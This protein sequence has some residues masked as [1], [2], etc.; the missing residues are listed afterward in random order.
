MRFAVFKKYFTIFIL[1]LYLVF[2][3]ADRT[4]PQ[5]EL[6]FGPFEA[7]VASFSDISL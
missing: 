3:K 5:A 1:S 2:V 6:V 4:L 7:L